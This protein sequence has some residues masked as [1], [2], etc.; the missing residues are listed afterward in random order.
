[1][2]RF[3]TAQRPASKVIVVEGGVDVTESERYLQSGAVLPVERRK[4]DACFVGRFH[5]QKGVLEL[6]D[7]WRKVVDRRSGARLAMIGEG[8]L[9]AE[10]ETRI[11]DC[12]LQDHIEIL[13]FLDGHPKFEVFKQ[14]RIMV[15]PATYDSGGMAAAEGMAWGLPGVGFDLEA[16]KTYYPKGMLKAAPGNTEEFACLI[17]NLLNDSVRYEQ[18]ARAAHD[19]ILEVWDWRKRAQRVYNAVFGGG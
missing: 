15:H 8:P 18:Q 7:I 13:G 10:L 2:Q 14:S 16:L 3:V 11:A 12:G 6:V 17:L 4:Y 5:Y 1:M 9:C 19:Y